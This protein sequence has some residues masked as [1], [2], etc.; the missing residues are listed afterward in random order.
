[1]KYTIEDVAREAGV[2]ITTVSRVINSNYPVKKETRK[3]VEAVIERLG[4]QPNPLASGL[5]R[6]RTFCL[7]V[8]V[9][10]ITNMFFTEVVYGIEKYSKNLGY[11][12]YLNNSEGDAEWERNNITKLVGRLVDGII[13]MDPQTE[14]MRSGFFE[15]VSKKIPL[16]CVNGY[17]ENMEVNFVLSNEEKGTRDAFD[18]LFSL[19]H[20]KIAFV[21]GGNSYS[22]DLKEKIYREYMD[23]AGME[24]VILNTQ[25]GNSTDVVENVA[26]CISDL[27]N[28]NN[29]VLRDTTAFFTCNDLMATGVINGCRA[30]GLDVPEDVSVIGFD[31]IILSQMTRPKITTVDQNMRMLGEHAAQRIIK[32]IEKKETRCANQMIDTKLILRE[33]CKSL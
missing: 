31:N 4:Y 9:P 24:P 14:N 15:E 30:I 18:Y 21:R 17:N 28:K 13:V 32:L 12:V 11:Q 20:K 5:I 10:G 6:N 29:P 7:G 23:V 19:R 22:Y 16:I 3:K 26:Q 8:L 1:M 33:S 2:S 25:D 27:Y